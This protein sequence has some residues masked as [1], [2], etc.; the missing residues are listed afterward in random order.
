MASPAPRNRRFAL[1]AA[2]FALLLVVVVLGALFGTCQEPEG[3]PL[4]Y[5]APT[6]EAG[7]GVGVE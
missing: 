1:L 4:D 6:E 2:A 7:P 3:E 5:V